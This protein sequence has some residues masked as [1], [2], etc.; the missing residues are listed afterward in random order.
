LP[1]D[2]RAAAALRWLNRPGQG[3]ASGST[4]AL[5]AEALAVLDHPALAPLFGPEGR[6]EVPLAGVIAGRVVGGMVDRLAVLPDRILL[7]DYKTNRDPPASATA[8]P[9]L[10]LRQMAAYAAVLAAAFPGRPV[11]AALF[12]TMGATVMPLPAPLLARYAPGAETPA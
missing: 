7:A 6:A 2:A 8:T 11:E 10:Y 4:A 9:V 12:W 3:L 1:P 5:A